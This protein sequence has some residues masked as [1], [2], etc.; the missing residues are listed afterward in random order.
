[1][2]WDLTWAETASGHQATG[3]GAAVPV[4]L[5]GGGPGLCRGQKWA[6]RCPRRPGFLRVAASGHEFGKVPSTLS[7]DALGLS[8]SGF[9][10]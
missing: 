10:L 9:T 5:G 8:H 4:G 2:K 6:A 7:P 1:M 3:R